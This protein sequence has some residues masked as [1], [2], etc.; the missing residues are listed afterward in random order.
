M[1]NENA[2]LEYVT[3]EVEVEVVEDDVIT[4]SGDMSF[5]GPIVK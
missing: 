4:T 3:P 2:K 1:M 5:E